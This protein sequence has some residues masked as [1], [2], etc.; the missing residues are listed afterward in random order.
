MRHSQATQPRVLIVLV[1]ILSIAGCDLFGTDGGVG[2]TDFVASE[3]FLFDVPIEQR[4]HLRLDGINGT[5]EIE[6]RSGTGSVVVAG[7]RLVGSESLSDAERHLD[8]LEVRVRESDDEV[9]VETVQPDNTGGRNYTVNY[10]ITLPVDFD[11]SI[12][13]VNGNV[14]VEDVGNVSINLVNGNVRL[15]DVRDDSFVDLTNGTI[16]SF[17]DSPPNEV[18]FKTVNGGIQLGIPTTTSASF[19]ASVVNGA[20]SVA[21]LDLHNLISTPT[22]TSGT[23]GDGDGRIQLSVINGNILAGGH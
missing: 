22:E 3:Q 7:E 20:V 15:T 18:D 12:G 9:I 8:D 6:G 14:F 13:N 17:H 11:V 10:R 21:N 2:N 1:T 16:D 4:S 19:F 23:L 5:V